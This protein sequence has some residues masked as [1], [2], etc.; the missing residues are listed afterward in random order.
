M[1]AGAGCKFI[2]HFSMSSFTTSFDAHNLKAQL[3]K[4]AMSRVGIW[5]I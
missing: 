5:W 4:T 2:V 3:K 1:M